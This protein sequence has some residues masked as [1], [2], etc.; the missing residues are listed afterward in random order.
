[1][2]CSLYVIVYYE[3][4]SCFRL[5]PVCLWMQYGLEY[6]QIVDLSLSCTS[7]LFRVWCRVCQRHKFGTSRQFAF[8]GTIGFSFAV[9]RGVSVDR[10][11]STDVLRHCQNIRI[12][13][14]LRHATFK[15]RFFK[16]KMSSRR[17][18]SH[19]GRRN[20]TVC[21]QSNGSMQDPCR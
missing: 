13:T 8:V 14:C 15:S 17:Y 2:I 12:S 6:F 1:M 19:V 5:K 16:L 18:R 3:V 10:D 7:L 9:R 20:H 21:S 11:H 4:C